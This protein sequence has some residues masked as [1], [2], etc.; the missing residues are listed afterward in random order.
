MTT[1]SNPPRQLRELF[2]LGPA[3]VFY[4]LT[5][6]YFEGQRPAGLGRFGYSRDSR[7][8]KR[9]V[10]VGVVM[11]EGWPIAHH[12]FRGNRLDQITVGEVVEDLRQRLGLQRM[13]LVGDRGMGISTLPRGPAAKR[14]RSAAERLPGEIHCP[15]HGRRSRARTYTELES[16][17]TSVWTWPNPAGPKWA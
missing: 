4:D 6:T 3:L 7:P 5:S 17:W 12:L 10:L 14:C 2:S 16:M 8:R 9:Q 15:L 1:P 13:V 11:M